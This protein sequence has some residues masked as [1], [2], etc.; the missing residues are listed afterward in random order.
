MAGLMLMCQYHEEISAFKAAS[1]A[2][3]KG[4]VYDGGPANIL[5]TFPGADQNNLSLFLIEF[6]VDSFIVSF[7]AHLKFP[8]FYWINF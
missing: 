1:L 5:C 4:L 3:G 6:F 2:A 7:L 8:L